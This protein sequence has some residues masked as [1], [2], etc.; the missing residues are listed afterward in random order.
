MIFRDWIRYSRKTAAIVCDKQ[1]VCISFESTRREKGP[2]R[3]EIAL[4]PSTD[5][6]PA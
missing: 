2:E 1:F 3:V 6:N 5:F 4:H